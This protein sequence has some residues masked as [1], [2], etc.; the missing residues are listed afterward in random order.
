VL[1]TDQ[2]GSIAEMAI[3]YNATKLGVDVYRPLSDGTQYDLIFDLDSKLWRVQC[4]WA[5]KVDDA[6]VVRCYSCRRTKS[7]LIRRIYSAQQVD[8]FAA[9]CAELDRYFLLPLSAFPSIS[10]IH[11]RLTPPRNNQRAASNW[12]EDFSFE[13]TLLRPGAVAQLGRATGWQPVGQG[14]ESPRLHSSSTT[15]GAHEFREHFG[16]YMERAA[17]GEEIAVTRRGKPY[18]RLIPGGARELSDD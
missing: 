5:V 15:V 7:G 1:T 12:A 14:F 2:K 6:V 16:W 9:Y 17:D 13:A 8:G 4:K 11:L 10:Q 18:V 3:A